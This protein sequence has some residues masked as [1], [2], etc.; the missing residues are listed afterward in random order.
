MMTQREIVEHLVDDVEIQN[1]AHRLNPLTDTLAHTQRA[2]LK[3]EIRVLVKSKMY[4]TIEFTKNEVYK[5]I[6]INSEKFKKEFND[7]GADENTGFLIALVRLKEK[8]MDDGETSKLLCQME[9]RYYK[10]KRFVY[11]K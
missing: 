8:Y 10:L 3:K 11:G 6:N 2:M 9:E 1:L 5:D 4:Q 7:E